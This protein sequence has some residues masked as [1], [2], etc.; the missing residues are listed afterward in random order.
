MTSFPIETSSSRAFRF[1]PRAA[2]QRIALQKPSIGEEHGQMAPLGALTQAWMAA[3]AALP[4]GWH[5]S[6]LYRFR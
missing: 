2:A 5:L 6:G 1:S 3:D 4:L